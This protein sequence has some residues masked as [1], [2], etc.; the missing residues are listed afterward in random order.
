MMKTTQSNQ[1]V[2]GTYLNAYGYLNSKLFVLGCPEYK[3]LGPM[4]AS[5]YVSEQFHLDYS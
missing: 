1:R 4:Y 2:S 5:S 3:N